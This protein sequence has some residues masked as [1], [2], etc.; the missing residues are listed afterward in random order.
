MFLSGGGGFSF[1]ERVFRG[2]GGT[3]GFN[4]TVESGFGARLFGAEEAIHDGLVVVW[5][6]FLGCCVG[7]RIVGLRTQ[8]F[9]WLGR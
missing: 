2:V 1:C 3:Y 6:W 9:A 8:V 4:G 7:K 5:L